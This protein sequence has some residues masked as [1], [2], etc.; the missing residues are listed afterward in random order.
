MLR[1]DIRYD[2]IVFNLLHGDD[3]GHLLVAIAVN[4]G[5]TV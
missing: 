5:A 2:V 4:G 1:G 3:M